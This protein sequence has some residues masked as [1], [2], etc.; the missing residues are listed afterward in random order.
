MQHENEQ[1]PALHTI[2]DRFHRSK[3]EQKFL[4][5]PK[6]QGQATMTKAERDGKRGCTA[7]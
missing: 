1:T 3:A 4:R 7:W 6:V 5:F 2:P